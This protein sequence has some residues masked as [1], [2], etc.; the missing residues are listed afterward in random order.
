MVACSGIKAQ[1]INIAQCIP[2]NNIALYGVKN[3][4]NKVLLHVC[5]LGKEFIAAEM[6]QEY[7]RV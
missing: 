6:K 5:V 4:M 2:L 3:Y 7:P 1:H